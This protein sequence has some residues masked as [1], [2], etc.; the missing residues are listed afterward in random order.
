MKR[1]SYKN[2]LLLLL[3]L[4]ALTSLC[5]YAWPASRAGDGQEY[6]A[7]SMAFVRHGTPDIRNGDVREILARNHGLG[8]D[9]LTNQMGHAWLNAMDAGT[10]SYGLWPNR[11]SDYFSYHFWFFPL[12]NA[13]SL[14]A[15]ITFDLPLYSSFLITNAVLFGGLVSV[16]AF[17]PIWRFRRKMLLI[18]LS[19]GCGSTF[20]LSWTGPEAMC[21][22]LIVAG[23]LL[24][25]LRHYGLALIAVSIAAQQ[26]PP[27]GFLAIV[28]GVGALW[29][30]FK[31]WRSSGAGRTAVVMIL[32]LIP[33]GLLL[34][35]SPLFYMVEFGTPN[36]I[37]K[38]GMTQTSL[39][40]VERLASLFLDPNQGM[41]VAMPGVFV[42]LSAA[43]VLGFVRRRVVV[44]GSALGLSV[45]VLLMALP[46]LTQVNWNAG[47]V[48]ISRY[49]YWLSAPL[50]YA[51]V[52]L[53]DDLLAATVFLVGASLLLAS[54]AGVLILLGI[55]GGG[56]FY[57]NFSPIAKWFMDYHPS[58]YVPVPEVFVERGTHIDGGLK[59][60][61]SYFYVNH[62][63]I[64]IFL[65]QSRRPFAIRALC[66]EKYEQ[67]ETRPSELHWAYSYPGRSCP[68]GISDGFYSISDDPKRL[69]VGSANFL[70]ESSGY[71]GPRYPGLKPPESWGVW[72]NQRYAAVPLL[73][74]GKVDGRRIHQWKVTLV[75]HP[76]VVPSA[77]IP[78][79]RV[80]VSANGV[81]VLNMR[82][83]SSASV[84]RTFVAEPKSL[85]NSESSLLL[86][87]KI[88][89]ATSYKEL[90]LSPD[91]S[92][93][94]IGLESICVTPAENTSAVGLY[95]PRSDTYACIAHALP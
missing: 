77:S 24:F 10:G 1:A 65:S 27:I 13:P 79:Q 45:L 89:T 51:C 90:G 80:F 28:I 50:I 69:I 22:V 16:I 66:E 34:M 44:V 20:Y 72:T 19:L 76:F 82:F 46:V 57:V 52:W 92:R 26:N 11:K 37:M 38:A 71:I 43:L 78:S 32:G 84:E 74:P 70:N 63:Y 25:E 31:A 88:P 59:D 73:L 83:T 58:W 18:A 42:A 87:F 47:E 35:A 3:S 4:V 5:W 49:A 41:I 93:L 60:G 29:D 6:L 55:L 15:C 36:L 14:L 64:R 54:Q 17:V 40:S 67:I 53:M 2:Y 30:G 48:I 94:G 21:F 85:G 86:G 39:M 8:S 33:G 7:M 61:R 68:T 95:Q 56:Y 91:P 81:E 23:L 75:F 9:Q 62:G 12:I